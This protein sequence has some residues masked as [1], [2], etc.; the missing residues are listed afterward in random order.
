MTLRIEAGLSK[1]ARSLDIVREA[2]GSPVSMYVSTI[3]YRT[4]L[5]LGERVLPGFI[6]LATILCY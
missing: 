3:E 5:S 4:S 2:T 6:A 1:S